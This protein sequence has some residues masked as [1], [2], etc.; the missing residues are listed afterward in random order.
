MLRQLRIPAAAFLMVVA[1]AVIF[2]VGR[3]DGDEVEKY[4]RDLAEEAKPWI[5]SP[6]WLS[7]LLRDAD[8]GA[9]VIDA[10]ELGNP[11][12]DQFV[13]AS[14]SLNQGEAVF[15]RQM[16]AETAPDSAEYR[17]ADALANYQEVA[18]LAIRENDHTPKAEKKLL[19][20]VKVAHEKLT[21]AYRE[22]QA[23]DR[24]PK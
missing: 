12:R 8:Y 23:T 4:R 20:M 17:V 13:A 3:S 22:W 1:V 21:D 16:L 7:R 15:L 9:E 18:T 14:I 10:E 2:V 19:L 24:L 11:T 6:E 5:K